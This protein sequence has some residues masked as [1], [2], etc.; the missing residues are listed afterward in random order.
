[1]EIIIGLTDSL[2][3]AVLVLSLSLS[4][5]VIRV[6]GYVKGETKRK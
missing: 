2:Q 1:M 6:A 3:I 4:W 5:L